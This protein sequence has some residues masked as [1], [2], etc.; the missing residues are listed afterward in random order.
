MHFL[1]F[2]MIVKHDKVFDIFLGNGS[3]H[4]MTEHLNRDI[5]CAYICYSNLT[6]IYINFE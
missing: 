6:L 3:Q 1:F 5:S 2:I 4:I